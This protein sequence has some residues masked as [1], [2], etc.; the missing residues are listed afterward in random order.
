MSTVLRLE[1]LAKRYGAVVAVVVD[2]DIPEELVS[3]VGPSG[4]GK[5]TLLRMA[6]GFVR[7][8]AGA[9]CSTTV[10]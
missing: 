10:T 9:C 8:D 3:F 6:G 2:A 5:T 1:R 4:C 7:P